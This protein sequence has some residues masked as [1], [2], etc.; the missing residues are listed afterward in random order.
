MLRA[1]YAVFGVLTAASVVACSSSSGLP[2][3]I[4]VDSASPTWLLFAFS[5]QTF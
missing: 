2:I 1:R 4:G 3:V 5:D